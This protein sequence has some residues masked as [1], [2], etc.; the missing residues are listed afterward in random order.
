MIFISK[1]KVKKIII[2]NIEKNIE[3]M[4]G[5]KFLKGGFESNQETL[6][7]VLCHDLGVKL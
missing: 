2:Q 3:M 7:R 1:R 5:M 6:I 4:E